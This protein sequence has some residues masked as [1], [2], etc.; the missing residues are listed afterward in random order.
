M[1]KISAIVD[2]G[3]LLVSDGAW[4]TYLFKKG[5]KS[6]DCPELWN[7]DHPDSVMEIASSYIDAGA[8]IIET[9]SFGASRFKLS[10][11]NLADKT[12]LINQR[13]AEIS[14]QAA[15][16]KIV[17]ASIGPTGKFLMMDDVSESD[18]YESF[19]EQAVA[20]EIGGADAVCI[21]TFYALDEAEQAIKAVKDNTDLEVIC[22]FSF[23]KN[24]DGTY[25]TLMGI[26]PQQMTESLIIC[27]A[28]IIGANCGVGFEAMIS[29]T[30][31]IREVSDKIPIL[32]QANAGL[33]EIK[34]EELIYS[35][36][37][38]VI[39]NIVPQII[40]AG[41]NIIG[42]C[43]GTTPEHIKVI[44]AIVS[45]YNNKINLQRKCL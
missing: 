44:R 16:D 13:S 43:C 4:G 20:F 26:S 2:T 1:N 32:V 39:K 41:A 30:K 8:D 21:E 3:K 37:P 19:K 28:D 11:Y 34:D 35:E 45:E 9:N 23:D 33:P 40:D 29:I 22:T 24:Q 38:D 15:K 27:G 6:G 12:G 25:R 17:M 5:L 7:L 18:L 10:Q 42:G 14:R 36:T 31:N